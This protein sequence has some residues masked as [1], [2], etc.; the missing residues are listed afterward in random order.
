LKQVALPTV[1]LPSASTD[2]P[3]VVRFRLTR[4]VIVATI[5]LLLA[6]IPLPSEASTPKIAVIADRL[7]SPVLMCNSIL[8]EGELD[9]YAARSAKGETIRVHVPPNTSYNCLV[10]I[11]YRLGARGVTGAE[12]IDDRSTP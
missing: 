4:S 12:F 3:P 1:A 5:L 7:R 10:A 9:A 2:R 8:S 11:M 6:E